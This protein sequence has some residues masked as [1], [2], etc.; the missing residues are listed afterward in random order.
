MNLWQRFDPARPRSVVLGAVVFGI[1][2][3]LVAAAFLRVTAE[4]WVDDAIALEEAA[5]A[6]EAARVSPGDG[7]AR[8]QVTAGHDEGGADVDRRDQQGAGL[9]AAY[10]FSGV[11]FGLLFAA[12]FLGMRKGQ[13]NPL[14]RAVVAGTVL[15]SAFTLSPW[16]KYPPNPPAVGDPGTISQ[17]QWQYAALIFLTFLVLVGAAHLSARLRAA[18]WVDDQRLIALVTA[19][20]A[21][22]LVL[23]AVLPAPPDP[24]NAPANL[25]WHFRVASLGGNLLLWTVLTLAFGAAATAAERRA[26]GRSVMAGAGLPAS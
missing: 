3:G 26:S 15:A 16:L 6:K 24:V 1:L 10:A 20:V 19:V 12:T 7:L 2:A 4:P 8:D 17:R 25:V 9:F 22:M 11:A 23:W 21:P 18:G 13:P 5:A 14:R